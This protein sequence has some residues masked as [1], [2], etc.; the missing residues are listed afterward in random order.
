MNDFLSFCKSGHL[1]FFPL[2]LHM[3]KRVGDRTL[4]WGTPSLRVWHLLV[5]SCIFT[6]AFLSLRYSV[7]HW[8]IFPITPY[9][10]CDRLRQKSWSPSSVSCV[11]ARKIVRRSCLGA[12]PRYNLVVDGDV[13]KPNKQTNKPYFCSLYDNPFF[14]T[15]SNALSISTQTATL[16]FCS[17]K[18]SSML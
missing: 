14:Q 4:P 5:W 3:E 1:W 9:L 7:I 10:C 15:L 6:L 13:K 12:R 16:F 2:G 11:A 18:P 17:W 8:C